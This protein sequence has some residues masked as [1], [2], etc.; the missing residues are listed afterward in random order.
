MAIIQL[1][2]VVFFVVDVAFFLFQV[3]SFARRE[4]PAVD[5]I[6]DAALLPVLTIL[7]GLT[8]NRRIGWGSGRGRSRSGR[9]G[10]RAL[11]HD[12]QS[13]NCEGRAQK[14]HLHLC[15]HALRSH[16][17]RSHGTLLLLLNLSFP[18]FVAH[19]ELKPALSR[20]V[21]KCSGKVLTI[22]E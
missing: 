16:A 19:S 15:R 20:N 3:L 12:G 11:R 17:L 7:Y 4:L 2:H 22:R 9:W 14:C 1:A 13:K 18:E 21:A 10:V 8:G 5:A 6:G